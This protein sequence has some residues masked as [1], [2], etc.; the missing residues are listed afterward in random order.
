M[1]HA[2]PA[3]LLLVRPGV[4]GAAAFRYGHGRCFVAGSPAPG[5]GGWGVGADNRPRS[6][7]RARPT[8]AQHEPERKRGERRSQREGKPQR[9]ADPAHGP[10]QQNGNFVQGPGA[11]AFCGR[12][13]GPCW[14]AVLAA[15]LNKIKGSI[16]LGWVS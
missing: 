16:L 7:A 1:N 12:V 10:T 5:G 15:Q 4:A 9:R 14:A 11:R 2:L 3:S 8:G 13:S 6:G